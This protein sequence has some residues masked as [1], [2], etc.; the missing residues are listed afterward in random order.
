[1]K[2]ESVELSGILGSARLSPGPEHTYRYTLERPRLAPHPRRMV[3]VG[4]NPSTADHTSNDQTIRRCIHYATRERCGALTM[5]NLFAYRTTYPRELAA[6]AAEGR[7]IVGPENDVLFLAALARRAAEEADPIVVCA[8]GSDG[9]DYPDRVAQV[10][11]MLAISP[12]APLCFGY[13]AAGQP[14]HPSRLANDVPLV[15]WQDHT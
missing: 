15:P 12:E 8:W 14:R 10:G 13:T 4:L 2:L 7:H 5:L 3:V 1:M 6:A 9:A 11:K